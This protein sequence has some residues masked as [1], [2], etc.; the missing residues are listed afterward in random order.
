MVAV[1]F[2]TIRLT[3]IVEFPT[4]LGT[5]CLLLLEMGLSAY[6]NTEEEL[7]A[8]LTESSLDPSSLDVCLKSSRCRGF[9]DTF[10]QGDTPFKDR[11][12]IR[13]LEHNGR[14]WALEGKHRVCLAKRAGIQTLDALVY[15]MPTDTESLLS[16][17]GEPGRYQFSFSLKENFTGQVEA[18]GTIAY[19]WIKYPPG[20]PPGKIGLQG[21]WLDIS[22]DT[23]GALRTVFQGLQYRVSVKKEHQKRSLFNQNWQKLFAT[24]EVE[25]FIQADHLKTKIWLT[26]WQAGRP[27]QLNTLPFWSM[28]RRGCWRQKD[29]E[30]ISRLLPILS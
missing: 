11:D 29:F 21:I 22:K 17:E 27:P 6:W 20:M 14:Y 23:G 24:I 30:Q 28:Y 26:G 4:E 18:Q 16:D 7:L 1:D 8:A 25:V 10:M 9:F 12:P 5:R 3:D 15:Q 19:L 13:L 2:Q